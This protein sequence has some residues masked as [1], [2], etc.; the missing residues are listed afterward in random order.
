MQ[1]L[2]LFA[3]IA[4]VVLQKYSENNNSSLIFLFL[5]FEIFSDFGKV[6]FSKFFNGILYRNPKNSKR[7]HFKDIFKYKP[8]IIASS[9]IFPK[10]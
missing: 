7:A 3:N 8:K 4:L 5:F 9:L 2:K 10:Y 1:I 6:L